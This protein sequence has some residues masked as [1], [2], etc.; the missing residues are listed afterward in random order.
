MNTWPAS[1]PGPRAPSPSRLPPAC[2]WWPG[3]PIPTARDRV[4]TATSSNRVGR[5]LL[6]I[7]HNTPENAVFAVDSHY[8]HGHRR[9]PTVSRPSPNA[10]AGRLLQRQRRRSLFPALADEWKQM[11]NATTG[12][13]HFNAQDFRASNRSILPSSWTVV[14]GPA[15]PAWHALISSRDSPSASFPDLRKHGACAEGAFCAMIGCY[16]RK[17]IW[18]L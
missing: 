6:W 1:A 4:P 16:P 18:R 17:W 2:F 12:L 9:T 13:N 5:T 7:R 11:S 14:H 8:L 3:Q 10:P 15:P